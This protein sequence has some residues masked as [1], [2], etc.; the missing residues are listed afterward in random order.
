MVSGEG[1]V[2]LLTVASQPPRRSSGS[3]SKWTLLPARDLKRRVDV[4]VS[5]DSVIALADLDEARGRSGGYHR[6]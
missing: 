3:T 5:I 2:R 4:P 1:E 6:R